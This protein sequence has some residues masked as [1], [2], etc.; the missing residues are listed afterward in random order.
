MNFKPL[1]M[2]LATVLV[3]CGD[4]PANTTGHKLAHGHIEGEFNEYTIGET[5]LTIPPSI[6]YNPITHGSIVQ[7]TAD[8]IQFGITFASRDENLNPVMI[9]ITISSGRVET[10]GMWLDFIASK[11][12]ESVT[13]IHELELREYRSNRPRGVWGDLVYVSLNSRILTPVGNPIVYRCVRLESG[14]PSSCRG[15]FTVPDDL[16]VEYKI[17]GDYINYWNSIHSD[18]FQFIF[19]LIN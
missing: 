18:V 15:S 6:E 1:I 12:W 5:T 16:F 8:S 13:E 9:P 19:E 3:S 14:E 2:F 10:R 11:E 17:D 7:G 4:P